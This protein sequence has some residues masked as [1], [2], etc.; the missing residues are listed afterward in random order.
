MHWRVPEFLKAVLFGTVLS[1]VVTI[2]GVLLIVRRG[3]WPNHWLV[4]A[5]VAGVGGFLLNCIA[6]FPF[7]HRRK[8]KHL[9]ERGLCVR[10]GYNLT[11]NTTG[12]CPECGAAVGRRQQ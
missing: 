7:L 10:C 1:V 11:G 9:R 5:L 8:L 12:T 4:F 3:G 2:I 6:G